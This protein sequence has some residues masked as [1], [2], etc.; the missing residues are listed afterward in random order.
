MKIKLSQVVSAIES[1]NDEFEYL[2]DTETGEIVFL[3]DQSITGIDNGELEALIE[4]SGARFRRFPTKYDIHEYR[5]MEN[6]VYSLPAGAARQ[7]LVTAICGKGA[8]RRFRQGIRYHRI[9]QQWYNF[10][11][12]AYR[13]IA[14]GWCQDESLEYEDDA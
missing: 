11:A 3:A 13:E 4:S 8:F 9:E 1:A 12:Q 14:I 6:F 2:Y 5:I 7:E 10:R